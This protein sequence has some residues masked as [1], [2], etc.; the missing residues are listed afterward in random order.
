MLSDNRNNTS[1]EHTVFADDQSVK[2]G[3]SPVGNKRK[4]Q[5][6]KRKN[7]PKKALTAYNI[8]F[9]ETREKI[10]TEHGK[11]DFQEM[12]RKIAALWKE[13]TDK[14]KLK[15]D[16]IASR[17][18]ARYKEEVS[19]YEQGIVEKSRRSS[20]ELKKKQAQ[21]IN[22]LVS[23]DPTPLGSNAKT[24]YENDSR[25]MRVLFPVQNVRIP[26]IPHD[27][28]VAGASRGP[29]E[30]SNIVHALSSNELQLAQHR[31]K[32][33]MSRFNTEG[34]S[35]S[36]TT[37]RGNCMRGGGDHAESKLT[38]SE[39]QIYRQSLLGIGYAGGDQT[40][41]SGE[42]EAKNLIALG[43]RSFGGNSLHGDDTAM[44]N[45]IQLRKRLGLDMDML[46][47]SNEI[48]R[49]NRVAGLGGDSAA[50]FN[51]VGLREKS[52][53]T[54]GL[55]TELRNLIRKR[56]ADMR[57]RH[58]MPAFDKMDIEAQIRNHLR[59]NSMNGGLSKTPSGDEKMLNFLAAGGDPMATSTEAEVRKRMSMGAQNQLVAP[60]AEL[61]N[62]LAMLQDQELMAEH[63]GHSQRT[64]MGMGNVFGD[65]RFR[66]ERLRRLELMMTPS[67]IVAPLS[68]HRGLSRELSLQAERRILS[69]VIAR[70]SIASKSID[71]AA[72][73]QMALTQSLSRF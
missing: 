25:N 50:F 70:G 62:R 44:S 41:A 32:E 4:R 45:D 28:M 58:S 63:L 73:I 66:E 1:G 60:D 8:F 54:F 57:L 43:L 3:K 47:T 40:M 27:N 67:S 13:I 39:M 15:F 12:V 56:K 23:A 69:G 17:D 31:L 33:D 61:R 26:N 18:L 34:E 55:G 2:K 19:E 10:L 5:N 24:Q 59:F 22:T 48:E 68:V 11:T 53:E 6:F 14:D 71:N 42:V 16:A 29:P 49:R 20:L 72:D 65:F 46:A 64:T 30:N 52:R 7:Y 9:K 36:T 51:E 37:V 38:P 35:P 21:T